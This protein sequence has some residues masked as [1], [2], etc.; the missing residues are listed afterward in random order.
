MTRDADMQYLFG[1]HEHL[2]FRPVHCTSEAEVVGF[3]EIQCCGRAR[4][5]PPRMPESLDDAV[6]VVGEEDGHLGEG[7]VHFNA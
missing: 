7:L 6:K 5:A 2:I 1:A 3:Q 4:D